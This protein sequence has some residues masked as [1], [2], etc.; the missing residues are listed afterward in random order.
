MFTDVLCLGKNEGAQAEK[1][2][3]GQTNI[4][5]NNDVPHEQPSINDWFVSVARSPL[6]G[7]LFGLVKTQRCGG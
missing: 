5:A 4:R 3:L 1:K 2:T 7:V 6:H